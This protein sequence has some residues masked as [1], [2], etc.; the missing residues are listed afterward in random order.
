MSRAARSLLA[1]VF[2]ASPVLAQPTWTSLGNFPAGMDARAG[3]AM[4]Y[5][6]T[7]DRMVVFSGRNDT[8]TNPP[9]TW[10]LGPGGWT[11][12]AAA[13]ATLEGRV[14][15][16]LTYTPARAIVLFGG[17]SHSGSYLDDTWQYDGSAWQV[18]P[19]P[20]PNMARDFH[21]MTFE[22]ARDRIVVFGGFL[23]S[24]L[25]TQETLF[26][27]AAGWSAGPIAPP[28]LLARWGAGLASRDPVGELV[29]F[30]GAN[31]GAFMNDTWLFDGA[32]WSAGP[33]APPGLEP[34][35]APGIAYDPV[36]DRVVLFGGNDYAS[37]TVYDD[38]WE[39]DGTGWLPGPAPPPGLSARGFLAMAYD[40]TRGRMV[41]T[42]GTTDGGTSTFFDDVWT[43]GGTSAPPTVDYLAGAG[44]GYPNPNRAVAYT[45]AGTATPWDVL[46]Y[47]SSFG[48]RVAA[49]NLDATSTEEAITGPGPGY[50]LSSHVRAFDAA[51]APMTRV[52]FYA[53]GTLRGGVEVAAA[54]IDG[55][56]YDEILTG[57]GPG[58][59]YGPHVRAFD[60]DG[61]SVSSVGKVSFF[62]YQA[63][64]YGVS[65]G[66]GDLDGDGF[67]E[68]LTGPGPGP[69]LGPHVRAF[70]YDGAAVTALAKVSFYAFA[71]PSFG[72]GPASGDADGDGYAEIVAGPGPGN[73]LRA[74]FS[75][76]DYDDV[77]IAALPGFST[78][79][80][81]TIYGC[82]VALG[83][84]VATA[85]L[86]VFAAPGP[87]PAASSVIKTYAY[88]AASL[89]PVGSGVS[90]FPYTYG[91]E[92]CSA[93]LGL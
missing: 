67:E 30:G 47:G 26:L 13:P 16:A 32:S 93:D 20:L 49:G 35:N 63:L 6:P 61:G 87:D 18:G 60:V 75:G 27:G 36:R 5:D 44:A 46:A 19:P 25:S 88:T 83:N 70:D 48:V 3:H 79:P 73:G 64:A 62:A 66:A 53:Y 28:G 43:Y 52:S 69:S 37:A 85:T 33:G 11:A 17:L 31:M 77:R 4:A 59:V 89:V 78:T 9:D 76:F 38:T 10:E 72:V 51:A 90:P 8:L 7:R 24:G 71:T 14:G 56:G 45:A 41:M 12:G 23:D 91:V 50:A 39:Y 2:L 58:V 42:G 84:V 29:L 40:S 65:V 92:V 57:A 82:N 21:A 81:L 22:A 1:G 34:R 80:Y 74:Q 55:D 68:I 86:E 15:H 54:E